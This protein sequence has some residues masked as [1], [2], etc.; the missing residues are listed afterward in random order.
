ML[1]WIILINVIVLVVVQTN[2]CNINAPGKTEIYTQKKLSYA[3]NWWKQKWKGVCFEALFQLMI[4]V[5]ELL[6]NILVVWTTKGIFSV[7]VPYNPPFM[8]NVCAKLGKLWNSQ[9]LPFRIVEISRT[10]FPGICIDFFNIFQ[11]Q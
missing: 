3:R 9:V 2:L 10:V 8:F 5:S 11:M 1:V 7:E 4:F 6:F